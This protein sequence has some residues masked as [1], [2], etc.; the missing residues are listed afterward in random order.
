M[1]GIAGVFQ[2]NPFNTAVLLR[3]SELMRH[4]GPDG[5]G[6][7]LIGEE[8]QPA[9]GPDTTSN[10]LNN[11]FS[12]LP[13]E[14]SFPELNVTGAFIHRRLAIIA[15]DESGHQPMQYQNRYWITYN[16]EIYNYPE[17]RS[18]LEK[19]GFSFSTTSDTEV[20]L[21]AYQ[22]WGNECLQRFNGMWAFCIYDSHTQK[23]FASRDRFGVKPFYYHHSPNKFLFASE[24]K[25]LIGSGLIRK[26]LNEKAVFDY[27]VFSEIEYQPHGFFD[28]ILELSPGHQLELD[29]SKF[30]LS[31]SRYYSLKTVDET[32]NVRLSRQEI[33]EITRE[34]LLQSVRI[35]LRADVEVGSC[36]SGGL[37]SSALV[38]MMRHLLP[39]DYP[40][41]LFTAVFPGKEA[42]E[43]SWASL[44]A[45]T[46][47]GIHHQTA[48]D[49]DALLM[50]LSEMT[51]ALDI[52]IWSTSTFAQFSVMKKVQEQGLKVVLDGQGGD[53]LFGGYAPH[54]YFFWKGLQAQQRKADMQAF[55][56]DAESFRRKQWLRFEGVFKAGNWPA[57]LFYRQYFAG[58]KFIE[59]SFYYRNRYRFAP[60]TRQISH[61]LNSRLAWEMDN[62]TLKAYLR[63]EDRCSMW[64]SVESRTPF[65]D[66][67][68]LAEWMF[69]LPGK[70]KIEQAKGKV[71]LKEA[72]RPFLPEAIYQRS[73]K[74]GYT[75]PN[76]E[77]IR[78]ISMRV[79]DYFHNPE[80]DNFLDRKRLL[81]SYDTFFQPS[82]NQDNGRV[83]KLISFAVWLK[84]L[85]R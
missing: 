83:F 82:G 79:K 26:T 23:I 16:G 10:C 18:S 28:E 81:K 12:W 27:L 60:H 63:C 4:R 70:L 33:I 37:D 71:L 59:P 43:S 68:D 75:T 41:H 5:E 35:R 85:N 34:K 47:N 84:N 21:A 24:H 31:V 15:P 22:H 51:Y 3:M 6:F 54:L 56:T 67:V 55:G 73:D 44:M 9:A 25:V 13:K 46:V 72:A 80:L 8:I 7:L 64:H 11:R 66:D 69:S 57:A 19:V 52:P 36:L 14:S 20:I 76:N 49:A 74:K 77:W 2:R 58:L 62:S 42:D 30:E 61:D 48:P 1:C 45:R 65:A 40:I 78:S 32:E 50:A 38:G 39:K 17:I 53:E 29:L